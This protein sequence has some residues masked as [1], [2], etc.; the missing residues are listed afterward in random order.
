MPRQCSVQG[1]ERSVE[2]HG[3][4]AMHAQRFRR[5]GDPLFVTSEETRRINNRTAQLGRFQPE[6]V[7]PTTYR[8]RHGRHE[9]RVIAEQMLGRPLLS[10]EI[11]HHIDGNR[12]NN[13]PSNLQVMTQAQ[14]LREHLLPSTEL[15]EWNGRSLYPKEWAAELGMTFHR[16]YARR[17]AGWSMDRIASTPVRKWKRRNA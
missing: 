2:S 1:C 3:L 4:C 13:D 9:H 16:F 11:V 14:H 7:K 8:K 6:G 17:R 5:H 12:H 15:I 10:R